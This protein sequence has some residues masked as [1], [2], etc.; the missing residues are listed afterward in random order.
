M[1]H[2]FASVLGVVVLVGSLVACA[3]AVH[4]GSLPPTLQ[5][6]EVDGGSVA[7]QNGIPVP[8][9]EYQ[10]RPRIDLGGDWKVEREQFDADLSLTDRS[11]ALDRIVELARGR[12]R[13]GFD[14]SS[15][16]R[17]AVPGTL[18]PP[19]DAR[20]VGAWY[21][22]GF[23]V[24]DAWAGLA[25][26]LKFAAVNY[27]ADV[28]LNGV[29]LGY[30]EGGYT[31][32]AFNARDALLV[33]QPNLLAVRVD[34]P[35][36]GTR[37]DIVPWGLTDWWN[38][39]GITQPVWLEAMPPV[40]A[41][42][43]DVVPHLDGA[44]VTVALRNSADDVLRTVA[45]ARAPA[46]N[47]PASGSLLPLASPSGPPQVIPAPT[48]VRLEV[49]PARVTPQNA[50]DQDVRS[51]I[52]APTALG[53]E[54]L[55]VGE[56][57][58]GVLQ[59]ESLKL[60]EATFRFGGA[61][62]WTPARPALY[63]LHVQVTTGGQ[64]DDLWTSFGLRRIQ[65]D[66]ESPRLLLNGE[67]V[68]FHG[69]GLHDE[70]LVPA[71]TEA[72]ATGHRIHSTGQLRDQLDHARDSGA[73]LIRAGH[74][75]ASPLLLMLADRLGFA[76]WEEIPLYHFTP[77]TFGVTLQRG[78]PQQMLR[79]MAL[80]DMNHPSVLFHGLANEST[81]DAERSDAL[82]R[83]RDIDR[84]ID[85]TRLTGQ[86]AYGSQ[87]AD[88][89]Q[90]PLD[91]AGFTFYYGV[92]Y[93]ESAAIDTEQALRTAHATNPKKPILVLEFGRWADD[94]NG[95]ALQR[96]IFTETYPAFARHADTTE[97]G[98]V[99]LATWW[100]LEDFLTMRPGIGI[101]H[102]GLYAADGTPR[103][104]QAVARSAFGARSGEGAALGIESN[105]RSA[106]VD[107]PNGDDWRLAFGIGYALLV[108][109]GTLA[110]VLTILLLAGGRATGGRRGRISR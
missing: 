63:V 3:P 109:F 59:G 76:V 27:L 6:Q 22:R 93:G 49:L 5:M 95:P 102:F 67:P 50:G 105:V 37:N 75:P 21:R 56:V 107:V 52:P 23:D 2:R 16:Q 98:F 87:P 12:E 34:N 104:A 72:E 20:Q 13:P 1:A 35:P 61:D 86:A 38:Y 96:R 51:L 32:F 15:W 77:L 54:P 83:L 62:Q 19:P 53:G 55:A 24:P 42:R 70:V 108:A 71:A 46:S 88:A 101:E 11:D 106:R 43:A 9:F 84:Q 80:R 39:G 45:P 81:G 25:V 89:T 8:T 65:V 97:G 94:P 44:D 99:G 74:T 7:I 30:H 91:V 28:W 17:L 85:G 90:A 4:A 60:V 18:N 14:D 100:T 31:P 103:P 69:V 92:F 82:S 26:T 78:I 29:Y 73:D 58:A 110:A 57:D 64:T 33:G 41:V 68:M 36:W 40:H 47:P 66:P 79:E 48:S 10:P